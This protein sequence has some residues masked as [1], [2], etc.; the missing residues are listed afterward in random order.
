MS[1]PWCHLQMAGEH[2][3]CRRNPCHEETKTHMILSELWIHCAQKSGWSELVSTYYRIY[4]PPPHFPPPAPS[5]VST[6]LLTL[7]SAQQFASK[8]N[9][10]YQ[11]RHCLMIWHYMAQKCTSVLCCVSERCISS[12]VPARL[13]LMLWSHLSTLFIEMWRGYCY[14]SDTPKIVLYN[15]FTDSKQPHVKIDGL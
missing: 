15:L 3:V 14:I 4:T 8:T 13:F 1:A 10:N 5:K 9:A 2:A 6:E 7:L 11:C 12:S